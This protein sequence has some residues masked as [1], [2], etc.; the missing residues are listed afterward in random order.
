MERNFNGFLEI[1]KISEFVLLY[2]LEFKKSLLYLMVCIFKCNLD[3]ISLYKFDFFFRC[4]I[5]GVIIRIIYFIRKE[6][7]NLIC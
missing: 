2:R 5:M 4:Y 7:G 6:K 3:F 1:V